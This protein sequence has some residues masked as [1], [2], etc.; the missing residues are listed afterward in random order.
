MQNADS[1]D[2]QTTIAQLRSRFSAEFDNTYIEHVIIPSFLATTFKGERLLLPMID[3]QFSKENALPRHVLGLLYEDWK[4]SPEEGITVFLQALEKRGPDNRRKR[5]VMSAFTPD[6]YAAM[7]RDKVRQFFDTILHAS[8]VGKPVMGRYLENYFDLF[9]DLHLGVKGDAIPADVREFAQSFHAVLAHQNPTQKIVHDNYMGVRARL[10]TVKQWISD[11]IGDLSDGETANPEKAFA[12]WWMRNSGQGEDLTRNDAVVEVL[13]D[14]MAISQWGNMIY[15][16][17]LRLAPGGDPEVRAWFNKTLEGD[18]DNAPAEIFA[19]L[20]R[21]VMELFR[22]ISPNRGSLSALEAT[23]SRP[24][25]TFSTIL[26]P[27][28]ATSSYPA[29]WQRP[30]DFDPDRFKKAPASHQID[31]ATCAQMGFAKCPFD[32]RAFEVEDGRN[33]AL[34]NSGFGTVYP[35]VDG[36]PLPVCDHAGFAPFGFGYRRCPAE[37]FTI[38]VFEDFLRKVWKSRIEFRKLDIAK[39]QLVPIGPG[40]V[41]GDDVGFFSAT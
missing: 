6:L 33:V 31:E 29:H 25:Q 16:I 11:R 18:S 15:E 20:T 28:A 21:F 41:V 26:I 13:H 32:R 19:P 7:Y 9:W 39:P 30:E 5:I 12:F 38:Q 4:V 27:H 3:V 40:M 10:A 35:V 2:L 1:A 36:K 8:H 17:M 23:G 34:H 14:F 24:D 22:T 37:Q